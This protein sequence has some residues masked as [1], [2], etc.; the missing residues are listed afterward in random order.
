VGVVNYGMVSPRVVNPD[1]NA[2]GK[3]NASGN[4]GFRSGMMGPGGDDRECDQEAGR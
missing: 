4:G 1:M 2:S 3:F